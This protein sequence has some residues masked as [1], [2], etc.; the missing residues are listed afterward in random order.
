MASARKHLAE[1][2]A[3]AEQ[4]DA[5]L[6]EI[7]RE[8]R[9]AERKVSAI[10]GRIASYHEQVESGA[11]EAEPERETHLADELA[12]AKLDAA[13]PAWIGRERGAETAHG[14]ASR[15]VSEYASEHAAELVEELTAVSLKAGRER[16]QAFNDWQGSEQRVAA[17]VREWYRLRELVPSIGE[18]S[19]PTERIR[20][21]INDH[22]PPPPDDPRW[23]PAPPELIE[24]R[25][26]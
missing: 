1:L 13:A 10:E 4:A 19:S 2:V 24:A 8:R 15:R 6:A 23:I 25:E 7:R 14:E 20:L 17:V 22:P 5:H 16:Q 3:A 9:I 11:I 12:A 18:P 26:E 21:A